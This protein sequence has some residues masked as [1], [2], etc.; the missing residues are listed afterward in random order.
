M[1]VC[2]C[3]VCVAHASACAPTSDQFHKDTMQELFF[4]Q[5][6]V[7]VILDTIKTVRCDVS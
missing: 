3:S 2:V 7:H 1:C 6:E 4:I 5:I